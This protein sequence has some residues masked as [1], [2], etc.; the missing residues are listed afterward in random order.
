MV[1]IFGDEQNVE[2]ARNEIEE[3]VIKLTNTKKESMQVYRN[4]VE[5]WACWSTYSSSYELVLPKIFHQISK[6]INLVRMVAGTYGD[7]KY[8]ST[9]NSEE[10]LYL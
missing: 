8:A 4:E 6:L 5:T 10:L 3:I 1:Q 2:S 9:N 7:K